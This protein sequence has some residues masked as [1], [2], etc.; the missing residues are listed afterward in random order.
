MVWRQQTGKEGIPACIVFYFWYEE[1]ILHAVDTL[2]F[3]WLNIFCRRFTF[4]CGDEG[5]IL[6]EE[7]REQSDHSEDQYCYKAVLERSSQRPS[8]RCRRWQ[9]M[10]QVPRNTATDDRPH[11]RDAQGCPQLS[12]VADR[13]STHAQTAL[14]HGIL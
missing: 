2:F 3:G 8:V 7:G 1:S 9:A 10:Q 5:H 6:E 13:R 12:Q 11:H 4:G 14:R